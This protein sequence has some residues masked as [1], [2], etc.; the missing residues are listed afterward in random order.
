MLGYTMTKYLDI[1]LHVILFFVY[2]DASLG[3][4]NYLYSQNIKLITNRYF[5]YTICI[6]QNL[7]KN[8]CYYCERIFLF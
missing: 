5:G 4:A 2:I 6:F 3:I 1:V 8:D 7:S